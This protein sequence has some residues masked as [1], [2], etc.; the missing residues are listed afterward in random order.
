LILKPLDALRGEPS[1]PATNTLSGHV[2][3]RSDLT[4]RA[5]VSGQQHQLGAHD[6]PVGQRQAGGPTLKL[7]PDLAVH[8]D[9]CGHPSHAITFVNQT[10]APSTRQN[11]RR[12]ALRHMRIQGEAG[13]LAQP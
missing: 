8:L 9:R 10:A 12:A 4:I 11:F 7:A 5:P 3:A 6:H 1:S 13:R 2:N